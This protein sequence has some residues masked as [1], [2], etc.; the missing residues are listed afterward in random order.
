MDLVSF[1]FFLISTIWVL[2]SSAKLLKS[3]SNL[4][5]LDGEFDGVEL[6]GMSVRSPI[7]LYVAP[8]RVG[9]M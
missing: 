5:I 1:T 7:K 3:L 4:A 2:M 6:L 8:L 9:I